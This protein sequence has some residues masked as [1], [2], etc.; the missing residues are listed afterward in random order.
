MSIK[1]EMINDSETWIAEDSV[2]AA[3]FENVLIIGDKKL[4]L[5]SIK[6][7]AKSAPITSQRE[8]VS[9]RESTSTAASIAPD[10]GDYGWIRQMAGSQSTQRQYYFSETS[11]SKKGIIRRYESRFGLIGSIVSGM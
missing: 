10:K 6:R 4:V 9:V 8:F 5:E 11:F 7:N 2:S 1:S 3:I